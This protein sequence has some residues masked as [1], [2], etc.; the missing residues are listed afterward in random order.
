MAF[1]QNPQAQSFSSIAALYNP[2]GLGGSSLNNTSNAPDLNKTPQPQSVQPSP[3]SS[4]QRNGGNNPNN[5]LSHG[6]SN[7]KSSSNPNQQ[8]DVNES[9]TNIVEVAKCVGGADASSEP[10]F[11]D[12]DYAYT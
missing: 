2:N 6:A 7:S 3:T 11:V 8:N 9:I 5:N 4:S 1:Y 10:G 12:S